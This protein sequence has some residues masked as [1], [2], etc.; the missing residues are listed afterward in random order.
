MARRRYMW[1]SCSHVKPMPPC[2]CM[3]RLAHRSAAGPAR[4]AA[5]AAVYARW[6]S[7]LSA[8]RAASHTAAVAISV[9]TIMLAQWCFTAW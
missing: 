5:T 9:A 4:V 7:P 2:T 6:S 1:A 3:L 8:A